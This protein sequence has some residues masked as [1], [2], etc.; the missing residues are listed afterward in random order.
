MF[1]DSKRVRPDRAW[2]LV[3]IWLAGSLDSACTV[4]SSDGC[5]TSHTCAPAMKDGGFGP[6]GP[7]S[8]AAA[9]EGGPRRAGNDG[10]D[11][12]A[13]E[14]SRDD[15]GRPPSKGAA[16]SAGDAGLDAD[17]G[18]ATEGG[19]DGGASGLRCPTGFGDC[20]H[21]AQDGCEV[22]LAKDLAHCG[23]CDTACSATGT[24][25]Q[26]CKEGVCKPACDATHADCNGDGRDGCEVDVTTS[27][28][29]CGI[30]GHACSSTHASARACVAGVCKPMCEANFADCSTPAVSAVDNGCEADLDAGS[31]TCGAC[32]RDCL[33]GKCAG[34]ECQPL[35]LASGLTHPLWLAVDS[36]FVHFTD[37]TGAAQRVARIPVWGNSLPAT[38]WSGGSINAIV[39]DGGSVIW[40]VASTAGAGEAPNGALYEVVSGMSNYSPLARGANPVHVTMNS[41]S[42]FWADGDDRL[43]YEVSRDGSD[44]HAISNALSNIYAMSA[45]ERYVY[46]L[47]LDGLAKLVVGNPTLLSGGNTTPGVLSG[48]M[49]SDEGY[50]YTWTQDF[51]TNVASLGRTPKTLRGNPVSITSS[52]GATV[53]SPIAVDSTFA[54]VPKTDGLYRLPKEG[55]MAV[56]LAADVGKQIVSIAVDAGAVYWVDSGTGTDGRVMKLAVF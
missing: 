47:T 52:E 33:G 7:E 46:I 49:A 18:G 42:F 16:T 35:A 5:A 24:A 31:G 15:A 40:A 28:D 10:I 1:V 39:A 2:L 53:D 41:S 43:I 13:G 20:N 37:G 4:F 44:T 26:E 54:Y 23:S 25:M 21:D 19:A 6:Q 45:D 56:R 12:A 9:V 48:S 36:S 34:G 30:C 32:G 22:E 3:S 11:G 38:V 51:T 14:V 8:D 27:K 50:L 17:A 29:D 55:G